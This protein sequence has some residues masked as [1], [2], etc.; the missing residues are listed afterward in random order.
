VCEQAANKDRRSTGPTGQ[1]W[2]TIAGNRLT[3]DD[4]DGHDSGDGVAGLGEQRLGEVLGAETELMRRSWRI[5]L[6]RG[7]ETTAGQRLCSGGARRGGAR[8]Q[9]RRQRGGVGFLGV[10]WGGLKG[11]PEI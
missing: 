10:R 4:G 2:R 1:G 3:G 11:R 5:G 9:R 7:G 8:A 6:R